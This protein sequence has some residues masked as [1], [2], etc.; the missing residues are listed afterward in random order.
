MFCLLVFYTVLA[1]MC[2]LPLNGLESRDY[3]QTERLVTVDKQE[4]GCTMYIVYTMALKQ[5]GVL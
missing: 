4:M 3:I 1:S 2:L 5:L